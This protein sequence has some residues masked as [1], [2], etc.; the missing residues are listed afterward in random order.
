MIDDYCPSRWRT[1]WAQ[2]AHDNEKAR[3]AY[4]RSTAWVPSRPWNEG[5]LLSLYRRAANRGAPYTNTLQMRD[6][7]VGTKKR[8][9]SADNTP[10]PAPTRLHRAEH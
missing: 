6:N 3:D 9:E 7:R 1:L 2:Y 5:V 4:D 8:A 10:G